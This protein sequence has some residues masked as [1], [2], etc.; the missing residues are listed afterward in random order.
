MPTNKTNNWNRPVHFWIAPKLAGESDLTTTDAACGLSMY[1][2]TGNRA[3]YSEDTLTVTCGNCKRS[4][5][6]KNLIWFDAFSS[7][8]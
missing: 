5:V 1:P 4:R 8:G 2:D 3:Q 6:V 7:K